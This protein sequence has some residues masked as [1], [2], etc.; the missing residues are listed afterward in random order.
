MMDMPNS[1]DI[2]G[3]MLQ[4][5]E[6][7]AWLAEHSLG[8]R[9]GLAVRGTDPAYKPKPKAVA[10][11]IVAADGD[12]RYIDSATLTEDDEAA[13]ASWLSDPGPPKAVHDTKL[14]TQA[15]ARIFR[16]GSL[17]AGC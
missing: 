11:A 6:L 13:L 10:L 4:D 17:V 12:G 5:N 7:A 14:V 15:L 8:N 3:R 16:A 9:F 2:R 1:F